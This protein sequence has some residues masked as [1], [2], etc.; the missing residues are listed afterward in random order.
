MPRQVMQLTALAPPARVRAMP[1]RAMI[2][3]P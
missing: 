3:P 2:P 1:A